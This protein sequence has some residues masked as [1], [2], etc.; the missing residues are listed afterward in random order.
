MTWYQRIFRDVPLI[1][2]ILYIYIYSIGEKC[3]SS[4]KYRSWSVTH[5]FLS[6][7]IFSFSKI[8]TRELDKFLIFFRY[9][10]IQLK[11]KK[12][13]WWINICHDIL[14]PSACASRE[15]LTSIF[16]LWG[17]RKRSVSTIGRSSSRRQICLPEGWT[18]A[19]TFRVAD[20]FCCLN[21]QLACCMSF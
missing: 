13:E 19:Q 18:L 6:A 14:L 9:P 21:S 7:K 4:V 3:I 15:D 10:Y 17:A 1:F 12:R 20:R 16:S 8:A 11:K 5:L 2:P